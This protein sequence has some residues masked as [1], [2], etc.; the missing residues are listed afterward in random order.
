MFFAFSH[1]CFLRRL[2]IFFRVLL[3]F[4]FINFFSVAF[5]FRFGFV[6]CRFSIFQALFFLTLF[7]FFY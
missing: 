1:D 3:R 7:F 5:F 4:L 2:L 6:V